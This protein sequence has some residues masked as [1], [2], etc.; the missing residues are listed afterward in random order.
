MHFVHIHLLMLKTSSCGRYFVS[1]HTTHPTPG[2]TRPYLC[3][4]TLMDVT[5]GRR[6]S[7]KSPG[8]C[9]YEVSVCPTCI[10]YMYTYIHEGRDESAGCGV[11]MDVDVDVALDEEVV[12]GFDVFVFAGVGGAEDGACCV[13]I[14]TWK[15]E[16]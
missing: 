6:K 15:Y 1:R 3:P 7:H 2:Y 13:N 11:Y 14:Q 8:C 4:D 16:D 10:S 12:H 9:R 5:L